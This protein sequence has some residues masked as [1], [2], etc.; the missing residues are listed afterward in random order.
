MRTL[1]PNVRLDLPQHPRFKGFEAFAAR[2]ILPRLAEMEAERRRV[3]R[4]AKLVAI[5]TAAI[6]LGL[7][8]LGVLEIIGIFGV[9]VPAILLTLLGVFLGGWPLMSFASNMGNFLLAK[10][11]EHLGLRHTGA[12]PSLPL[13]RFRAAALRHAHVRRRHRER[14][15]G[16]RFRRRRS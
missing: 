14:K 1:R 15:P 9:I 12:N 16:P 7:V 3:V 2:E 6:V 4:R 5:A 11:C 13:E 8:V 10:T